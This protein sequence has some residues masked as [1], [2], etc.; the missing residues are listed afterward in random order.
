[1]NHHQEEPS[2]E[3]KCPARQ[4]VEFCDPAPLRLHPL[5][6]HLPGPDVA[7]AEW[8][9]FV[10]AAS[11]A[12]PEGLPAIVVTPEGLIMDGKR[13]W[14]AAVQLQWKEIAYTTRPEWEAA[15]LIVDS[16]MGQRCLT[17][18]AKVYLCLS[19]LP[20][21]AKSAESRRLRNLRIGA[22]TLE[23]P[24][25][26]PKPTQLDSGK[27]LPELCERLGCSDELVRQAV[28]IRKFFDA[29]ALK[30]HKFTFQDGSEATLREYWEP[31][32]LDAVRP[33]G[34][35]DV[36]KGIGYF[37]DPDGKPLAHPP[38]ERNSHF[39][40][41]EQAWQGWAKQCA[42]WDGMD[43]ADRGRAV[44][45]IATCAREVPTEVLKAAA[46]AFKAEQKRRGK[47]LKRKEG[48]A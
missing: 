8:H 5:H 19:M 20:D 45:V 38:P 24:F 23:K 4:T 22:K 12:G 9:A 34:L 25:N 11:A 35:G 42:K 15:A 17:K 32:I 14:R 2:G 41:F 16:L 21:Y 3:T 13:R 26:P 37:V 30:D 10:D 36:L 40:Y 44:E 43:V 48:K 7:G 28:Q 27:G 39:F 47:A 46:K 1:M 33:K 18:G 29:P 6:K 31:I